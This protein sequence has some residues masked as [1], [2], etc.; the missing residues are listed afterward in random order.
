MLRTTTLLLAAALTML[1][2]QPALAQRVSIT[3]LQQ[4]IQAIADDL[5]GVGTDPADCS[6]ELTP[7]VRERLSEID[8][9]L[10]GIVTALCDVTEAT[11]GEVPDI[12]C[13]LD[14]MLRLVGGAVPGEGR[15]EILFDEE[16]GTVCD[17]AFGAEEALVAC[18]QL[19]FETGVPVFGS[20]FGRGEGQ[21][22][23]DDVICDGTEDRLEDCR[24][25][26]IGIH[27]CSHF[28]DVGVRCSGPVQQAGDVRL[29]DGAG[30]E[31]GRLEV[32]L[33]SGEWGT[34]CDDRFDNV[35]A[36]VA[37]RE[38][39]F[40]DGTFEPISRTTIPRGTGAIALDDVEC[41]GTEERLFDCPHRGLEIHNCSHFEDVTV[42]CN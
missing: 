21:I 24:N 2:A 34:V 33:E 12:G 30:P 37:C 4:E 39:G 20:Q 38:L 15:L 27:N 36:G 17:D 5:C 28:E 8:S 41:T 16:W 26:G 22:W 10:D 6:A 19:G 11:T 42:T 7:S 14:G 32:L 13:S 35:D 3:G 25:R 31:N 23:L 9:R 1:V 29:Q 40:S 18:R